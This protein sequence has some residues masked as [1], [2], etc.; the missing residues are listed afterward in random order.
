MDNIER[1]QRKKQQHKARRKEKKKT[2]AANKEA[3]AAMAANVVSDAMQRM[4]MLHP[5][6]TNNRKFTKL[7]VE[8]M[9]GPINDLTDND[10]EQ[11][12]RDVANNTHLRE[13]HIRNGALND[14][15]M[16]S[17]FRGLTRSNSIKE[18]RLRVVNN[19]FGINGARS[20]L[21]F[22]QNASNLTELSVSGNN[23]TSEG[24]NLLWGALRDSPIKTLNCGICGIESIEIN[25]N[26]IPKC[27][28]TLYLYDN[29]IN[30]DGCRKLAKLLHGGDSTMKTLFLTKNRIDDESVAILVNVLQNNSSLEVLDL[31]LNESITNEG[32]T[33]LLKLVNNVSSIKATLKSNH[34]LQTINVEEMDGT[35]EIQQHIDGATLINRE[36]EHNPEAAGRAKVIQSQLHSGKRAA[37]C[38][39]QGVD[40]SLYSD[41]DPLHLPE[42]LALVGQTHGHSEFHVAL[43]SSI[44]TLFSTVDRERCLEQEISFHSAKLQSLQD[45]LAS[46]RRT[47]GNA[48]VPGSNKRRRL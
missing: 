1:M 21:P 2:K 47:K 30:A 13:L 40:R 48:T 15:K 18:I 39:L 8:G 37:L 11:F 23:I 3:A 28:R 41:I 14:E 4:R 6:L 20:M 10:W 27:L 38:R 34:T 43:K 25:S 35:G 46:I 29:R 22:L 33:A 44:A 45:E 7:S 17:L 32:K 26:H 5:A 31:G 9:Y 12:G 16:S 19:S 24:F 36:N 42:V